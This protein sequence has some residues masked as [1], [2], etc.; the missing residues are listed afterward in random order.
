MI[1]DHLRLWMKNGS[2]ILL[3]P[4]EYAQVRRVRQ[5]GGSQ[6]TGGFYETED[7]HGCKVAFEPDMVLMMAVITEGALERSAAFQ[8]AL[9]EY[10]PDLS[11]DDPEWL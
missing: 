8:E 7:I 6:V 3:P 2:T 1:V 5:L 9:H 4:E 10:A 11:D